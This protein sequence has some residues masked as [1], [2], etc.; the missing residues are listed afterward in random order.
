[1]ASIKVQQKRAARSV[2]SRQ[3]KRIRNQAKAI[4]RQ[5]E[6]LV[7]SPEEFDGIVK[8][9]DYDIKNPDAPGQWDIKGKPR[10]VQIARE[11]YNRLY[12]ETMEKKENQI[13]E[14]PEE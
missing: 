1:M 5:A 2:K 8:A 7:L 10:K 4:K 12:T 13:E 14:K 9:V 3:K 11:L 6:N